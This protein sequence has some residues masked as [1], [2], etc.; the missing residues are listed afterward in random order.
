MQAYT[1]KS[2]RGSGIR[3]LLSRSLLLFLV[4]ILTGAGNLSAAY[5]CGADYPAEAQ[6]VE[7][8]SSMPCCA[9]EADPLAEQGHPD[10]VPSGSDSSCLGYLDCSAAAAPV[11]EMLPAAPAPDPVGH[12][13]L[14]PFL[15]SCDPAAPAL[16]HGSCRRP[17]PLKSAAL[18]LRHCVFLI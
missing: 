12:T 9:P 15:V 17:P 6:P 14:S 3:S 7:P 11:Q 2:P 18:H 4:F 13:D 1:T 8:V 10:C 16:L 5:C